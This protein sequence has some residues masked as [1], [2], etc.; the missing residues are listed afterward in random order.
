MVISQENYN[1]SIKKHHLVIL[2]SK[3][4]SLSKMEKKCPCASGFQDD[5]AEL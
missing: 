2:Q 3:Y 4:K 5:D 1:S